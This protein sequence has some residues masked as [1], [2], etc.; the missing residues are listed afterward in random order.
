MSAQAEKHCK[1]E[2]NPVLD[3]HGPGIAAVSRRNLHISCYQVAQAFG[4]DSELLG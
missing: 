3:E 2:R 1:A 4:L